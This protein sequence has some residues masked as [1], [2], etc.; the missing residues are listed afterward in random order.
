MNCLEFRRVCLS[1]PGSR[2][3]GYVGHREEC[4]DCARYADSVDALDGKLEEAMRVP[5]PDDLVN[6]IKLR[7]VIQDEQVNRRIRPMQMAVAAGIVVAVTLG[8]LFGY[9]IHTANRYASQLV[10][11]AVDHT[12][13]ERQGSH[14]VA[15]HQDP[16]RQRERFKQVLAAFGGKVMDD[17]LDA[18]GDILHVQV[19]AL[20]SIDGPVA[21]AVFQGEHGEVTVYYVFGRKLR[22]REDFDQ[23]QFKGMLVPVGEGNIAIVGDPGEHL[24]AIADGLEQAI[25]WHI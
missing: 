19:C 15:E 7:H 23:G 20:D 12:R 5:A 17:E 24:V 1:D 13:M 21:H 8:T 9:Q 25:A 14:F 22:G 10:A 3:A 18:L 4:E 16:R 11:S 6:R 2:D